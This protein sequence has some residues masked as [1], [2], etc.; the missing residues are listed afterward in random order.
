MKT[1]ILSTL[2]FLTGLTSFG[3]TVT[4]QAYLDSIKTVFYNTDDIVIKIS[5]GKKLASYYTYL[6]PD[7]TIYFAQQTIDLAKSKKKLN[8]QIWS[9][10]IMGE[11][12]MN[13]AN[14]PKTL[15]LALEALEISK[16]I[17]SKDVF[18]GPTYYNLS[19]LYFQI[20]DLKKARFYALASI[21]YPR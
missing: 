6:N 20:G 11:G 2:L 15:E 21:E 19:D 13:K 16:N 10:A 5:S 12:Y 4:I 14:L 18:L 17:D 7:S 1:K 3:Q 9:M 8:E